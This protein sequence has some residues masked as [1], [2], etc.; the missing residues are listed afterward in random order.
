MTAG[1]VIMIGSARGERFGRRDCA[2]RGTREPSDVHS[3]GLAKISGAGGINGQ[4][5][6]ARSDRHGIGI[7]LGDWACRIRARPRA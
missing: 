3:G 2:I 5:G 7:R 6:A 1:R 4:H